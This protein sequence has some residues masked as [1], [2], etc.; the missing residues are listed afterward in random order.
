M[1]PSVAL[2]A[3]L[4]FAFVSFIVRKREAAWTVLLFHTLL[5]CC[6]AVL[7]VLY[8]FSKTPGV[9]DSIILLSVALASG[10]VV[11]GEAFSGRQIPRWCVLTYNVA[12]AGGLGLLLLNEMAR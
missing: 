1:I 11:F 3:I 2:A 6:G 8:A 12:S 9:L 5:I 4:G 10:M 7:L